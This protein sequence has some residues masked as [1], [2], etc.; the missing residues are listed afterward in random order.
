M[1]I[2]KSKTRTLNIS[3]RKH[4]ADILCSEKMG[5]E[6]NYHHGVV[7]CYTHSIAVA[8]MSIRIAMLF[9]IKVDI[10][11]LVHGALLH[12][13]YLYDWHEP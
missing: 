8:K 3:L 12:D 5:K 4:G 9:H 10:N 1:F 11:S 6:K 13:C 2:N 7:S